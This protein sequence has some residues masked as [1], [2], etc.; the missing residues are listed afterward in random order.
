MGAYTAYVWSAYGLTLIV[1]I[2]PLIILKRKRQ[3]LV[4]D[5]SRKYVKCP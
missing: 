2:L 1:L 3:Q 5:L 4:K